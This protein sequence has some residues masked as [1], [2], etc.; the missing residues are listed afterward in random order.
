[1]SPRT[2]ARLFHSETR[3]TP[4]VFAEQA[5]A[6]A[7]RCKLVETIAEQA[8]SA[9]PS[10]CGAHFNAFSMSGTTGRGFDQPCSPDRRGNAAPRFMKAAA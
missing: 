6:D 2:F 5:R 10:A 4:A 3:D 9:M 1:M 8:A 7:A